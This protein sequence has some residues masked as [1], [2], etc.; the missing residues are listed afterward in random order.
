MLN[1]SSIN[2]IPAGG[3][4]FDP[5]CSFFLHNSKSIGLRLLKLSDFSY[6]PKAL[7]LGLKPG[8][9]TKG[10]SPSPDLV[11]PC[12]RHT[13]WMTDF[14]FNKLNLCFDPLPL[15]CQILIKF[16]F[17]ESLCHKETNC[18][19][20]AKKKCKC[21]WKQPVKGNSHIFSFSW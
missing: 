14:S 4:Q 5:P 15:T 9:N 7:R 20:F 10:L 16:S 17:L 2:P 18:T 8:F 1:S 3:G 19:S 11:V 12:L 6:I 13:A 21:L